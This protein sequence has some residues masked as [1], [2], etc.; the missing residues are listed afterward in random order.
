M[1][2]HKRSIR[3]HKRC[4]HSADAWFLVFV[5]LLGLGTLFGLSRFAT[6]VNI[7]AS[8]VRSDIATPPTARTNGTQVPAIPAT[9]QAAHIHLYRVSSTNAGLMQPSVDAQGN[10]WVGE[11]SANRLARLDSH[12]GVVTTWIPPHAQSDIMSTAVDTHGNVWFVEQDADY[13]GRFDPAQQTFH[14]FPLDTLLGYP[15]GPQDLQFDAS[16]FLWFTA[17]DGGCIGRL[18]PTTGAIQTWPVPPPAPGVP[19]TP[20]GLAVTTTEQVWFG[21]LIGGAIGHLDPTTGRVTFYHLADPQ[22]QV[23]S[24]AADSTGRL[25]FTEMV[26]GKLGMIDPAAGKVTEWPVPTAAGHVA[27]LYELVITQNDDVWFVNNG[28]TALVRYMP[29][30]PGY[31]FFQLDLPASAPYGLA[32]APS[33]KLWFTVVSSSA[34]YVGEMTP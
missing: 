3:C 32:L 9:V 16:G 15:L 29:D 27:A 21:D 2:S 17:L 26:P 33:G 1:N 34:N 23:F 13:I 6:V 10:V 11:M 25:W 28:A 31:M 24:L 19:S 14:M 7:Q 12:T 20:F 30:K 22:A 4:L 18:D 5:L 8:T